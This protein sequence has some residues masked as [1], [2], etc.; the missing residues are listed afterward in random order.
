MEWGILA[1]RAMNSQPI[2]ISGIL[3]ENPTQVRLPKYD[4]VVETFTSDRAERNSLEIFPRGR[5]RR[6]QKSDD[7]SH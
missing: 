7:D 2:V 5:L 6:M 1:K 3:A 4:H